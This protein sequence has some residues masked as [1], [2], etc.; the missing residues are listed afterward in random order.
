MHKYNKSLRYALEGL[1]HALTTERSLKLFVALYALSLIVSWL[2]HIHARDWEMVILSGGLFI[3]VELVNTALERFA[4]AFYAHAK[5]QNDLHTKAIKAT[6]DIAAGAS[7]VCAVG[8]IVILAMI[9]FP[10]VYLWWLGGM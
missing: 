7:L 4:D 9:Y 8:W 5:A 10:H 3:A 2:L 1:W 6:K